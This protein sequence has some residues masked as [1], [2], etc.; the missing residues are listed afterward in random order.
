MALG[1]DILIKLREVVGTNNVL[2]AKEDLIAYS[3]DGTA[4]LQ[5]LPGCVVFAQTTE[6]VSTILK[7]AKLNL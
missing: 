6:Q 4:A 5:L 3:F 1:N 7:L 2:T